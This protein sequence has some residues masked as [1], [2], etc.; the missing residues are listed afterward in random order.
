MN[1]LWIHLPLLN[2]IYQGDSMA[3]NFPSSLAL[4]FDFYKNDFDPNGNHLVFHSSKSASVSNRPQETFAVSVLS[5]PSIELCPNDGYVRVQV[6]CSSA[7]DF[8]VRLNGTVVM[9][10]TINLNTTQAMDDTGRSWIG[11]TG[12]SGGTFARKEIVDFVFYAFDINPAATRVSGYPPGGITSLGASIGLFVFLYTFDGE[13]VSVDSALKD[14]VVTADT[15]CG[16][17]PSVNVGFSGFG[18]YFVRVASFDGDCQIQIYVNG[19]PVPDSPFIFVRPS[20]TP[21]PSS[22]SPHL[23]PSAS[24]SATSSGL[25]L[26]SNTPSTSLSTGS[27]HSSTPSTSSN[28][29]PSPTSISST[30]SLLPP[31]TPPLPLPPELPPGV[32]LPAE[33]QLPLLLPLQLLP[34]PLPLLLLPLHSHP[35][36][37]FQQA[38]LPSNCFLQCRW[39]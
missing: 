23:V 6:S 30:L 16:S 37:P 11:M 25:Q 1:S 10:D 20:T 19:D 17:P 26:I 29:T 33:L 7:Y 15:T 28:S 39:Q 8:I 38:T 12:A 32:S 24:A 4:E 14:V 27:S 21:S 22:T 35:L 34:M 2:N 3:Y 13:L 5:S 18:P 36:L 31:P 9:T